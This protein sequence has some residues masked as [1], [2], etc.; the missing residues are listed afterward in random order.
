M[1]KHL[2]QD[3]KWSAVMFSIQAVISLVNI[4]H[5]RRKLCCLKKQMQAE[6]AESGE[7]LHC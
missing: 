1:T 5:N 6:E 3:I 2:A 4:E 7:E